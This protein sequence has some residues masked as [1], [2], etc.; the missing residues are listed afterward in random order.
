[1]NVQWDENWEQEVPSTAHATV[2]PTFFSVGSVLIG[3]VKV[4]Q[5]LFIRPYSSNA[6]TPAVV[7]CIC[8]N[9]CTSFRKNI[10]D[11]SDYN[12][13][14]VESCRLVITSLQSYA[15]CALIK[16][17]PSFKI[18]FPVCWKHVNLKVIILYCF[19]RHIMSDYLLITYTVFKM[20]QRK[21]IFQLN[22]EWVLL[23]DLS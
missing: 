4:L 8:I 14:F 11:T 15:F 23:H 13:H 1:M 9:M 2:F 20:L 18:I 16:L 6:P 10:C 3:N 12:L 22:G 21:L 5:L 19:I 17:R 7:L